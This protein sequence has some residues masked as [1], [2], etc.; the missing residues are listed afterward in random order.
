MP[1]IGPVKKKPACAACG[2]TGVSSKGYPCQ[3]C[4]L[5]GRVKV[6]LNLPASVRK[7]AGR[8]TEDRT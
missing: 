4:V 5:T 1:K 6:N 7:T 2:G 8:P 3:P